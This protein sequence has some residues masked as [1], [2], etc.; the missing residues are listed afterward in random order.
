MD[1]VQAALAV[2]SRGLRSPVPPAPPPPL[3]ALMRACWAPLP[4][5]RPD[6]AQIVSEL[7]TWAAAMD[8]A[9]GPLLAP[10]AAPPPP[11]AAAAAATGG[12]AGGE[13]G[14][15]GAPGRVGAP[16]GAA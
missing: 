9:G 10:A 7:E 8:G 16:R 6:F 15:G 1:G 4:E 5:Q 12:E 11:P 2:M 3:A 14:G 13:A